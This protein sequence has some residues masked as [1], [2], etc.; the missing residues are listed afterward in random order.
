MSWHRGNQN[1]R[2]QK[3][4]LNLVKG[5]LTLIC[6]FYLHILLQELEQGIARGGQLHYEA[7][8]RRTPRQLV[9]LLCIPHTPWH[10]S[11]NQNSAW[12]K[13]G[14]V[15]PSR[16]LELLPLHFQCYWWLLW[17]KA[18]NTMIPHCLV[19]ALL[20]K[21]PHLEKGILRNLDHSMADL[22]RNQLWLGPW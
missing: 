17:T 11:C 7:S 21:H 5:R 13:L 14:F 20:P 3:I 6:P 8:M 2:V 9:S 16:I 18:S 12:L 19:L 1:R 22:L 15:G 4:L 10:R